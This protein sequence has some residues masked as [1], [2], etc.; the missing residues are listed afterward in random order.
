MFDI[1]YDNGEDCKVPDESVYKKFVGVKDPVSS[2]VFGKVEYVTSP[3]D[4]T[5]KY[6][7]LLKANESLLGERSIFDEPAAL[8]A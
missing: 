2:L 5:L 4:S 3:L 1:R 7:V 6:S 8:F